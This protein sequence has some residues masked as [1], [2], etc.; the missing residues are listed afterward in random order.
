AS[1]VIH[2]SKARVRGKLG[3][4]K[5]AFAMAGNCSVTCAEGHLSW[6]KGR[7]KVR[8]APKTL[9]L[10]PIPR[11][12]SLIPRK[13]REPQASTSVRPYAAEDPELAPPTSCGWRGLE[14]LQI[15]CFSLVTLRRLLYLTPQDP[16][17]GLPCIY[18]RS[19]C[20]ASNRSPT[21]RFLIFT[22]ASLRLLGR[23][24]AES[25]TC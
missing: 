15:V 4:P 6:A 7:R 21:K 14:A 2:L 23:T 5:W 24:V 12:L 19:S 1:C 25:R 11:P 9:L 8:I 10:V 22:K 20:S 18:N 17:F 3:D 13:R 16:M